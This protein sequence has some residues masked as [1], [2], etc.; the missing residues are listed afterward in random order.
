MNY[1]V[2]RSKKLKEF[3]GVSISNLT[4]DRLN[5]IYAELTDLIG[6]DNMIKIYSNYKGQQVNFPIKL[7]SKDYIAEQIKEEYNG[8][9]IGSLATKFGY[10]ERWIRKIVNNK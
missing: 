5:S 4:P 10:S 8:H 9:N 3:G 6:M 2:E 1:N 7:W